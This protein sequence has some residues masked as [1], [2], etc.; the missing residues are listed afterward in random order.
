LD[1]VCFKPFK[2]TFKK[3]K[4]IAMVKK[5]YIEPN[6]ITLAGWIYKALDLRLTRKNIMS[7]FK[8]TRIWP[9]NPKAMD[10]KTS[11]HTLY[12]L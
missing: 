3:E 4:N 12:T 1:V 6:K 10:S 5:N 7:G 11:L 2:T 9:L 8:G